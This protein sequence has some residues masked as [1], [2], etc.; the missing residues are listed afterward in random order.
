M[1]FFSP[2]CPTKKTKGAWSHRDKNGDGY[3]GSARDAELCLLDLVIGLTNL[4]TVTIHPV[5]RAAFPFCGGQ[6]F[7][8]DNNDTIRATR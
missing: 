1:Q 3:C 7:T 5:F 6:V 4:I 8:Y 2:G